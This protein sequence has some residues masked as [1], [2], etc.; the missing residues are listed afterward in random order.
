MATI[1]T[2][3]TRIKVMIQNLEQSKF[4]SS[5]TSLANWFSQTNSSML[6]FNLLAGLK[7]YLFSKQ[8]MN[9]TD[10]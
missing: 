6:S 7:E 10:T 9:I 8:I 5:Q 4:S 3:L 1:L 2:A